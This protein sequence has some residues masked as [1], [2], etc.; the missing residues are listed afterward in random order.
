MRAY[1]KPIVN[2]SVRPIQRAVFGEGG[3]FATVVLPSP[4]R[5]VRVLSHMATYHSFLEQQGVTRPGE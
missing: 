2:V 4:L 3:P 1:R 5:S